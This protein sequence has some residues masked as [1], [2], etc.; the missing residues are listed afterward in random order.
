MFLNLNFQKDAKFDVNQAA[1]AFTWIEEIVGEPCE[2]GY[3][4]SDEVT[5]SLKDGQVLCKSVKKLL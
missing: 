1:A 4:S 5:E 2:Q 3:G